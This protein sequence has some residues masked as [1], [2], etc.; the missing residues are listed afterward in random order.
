[1]LRLSTEET[2]MLHT[3]K[4]THPPR[5]VVIR[6]PQRGY[7]R[8]ADLVRLLP[9]WPEELA[10]LSVA[11][12]SRLVV[13]LERALRL[14]RQRGISGHWTY[15]LSRHAHLMAALRFERAALAALQPSSSGMGGRR[16]PAVTR[17]KATSEAAGFAVER[18]TIQLT[19][20]RQSRVDLV[21]L[22]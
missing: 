10:D 5:I 6:P 9:L 3:A 11:G 8:Q 15:D 21:D 13:M 16:C 18:H 7:S 20:G 22:P 19:M 12:R 1:M 2:A 4:P 17:A 14:E